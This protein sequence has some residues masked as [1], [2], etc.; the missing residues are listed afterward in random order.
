VLLLAVFILVVSASVTLAAQTTAENTKKLNESSITIG[1]GKPYRT[2]V[3][4]FTEGKLTDEDFHQASL[5]TSRVVAHLSEAEHILSAG[6]KDP[7]KAQ[8]DKALGLIK[9]IRHLL[10]VT[11]VTTTVKDSSGST[12]YQYEDKV[13]DDS[14]PIFRDMIAVQIIEPI[15]GLKRREAVLKGL[16]LADADLIRTS[17]LVN[18]G[19]IERRLNRAAGLLEKP[20]E[21]ARRSPHEGWDC[22]EN[23]H[24]LTSELRWWQ[25]YWH[26]SKMN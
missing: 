23:T 12:V 2:T 18:L 25:K 13:Q 10:P 3:E 4:R 17:V 7:A 22:R 8:I 21:A 16:R 20:E 5:L 15:A 6:K 19:F 14:I 9:I 24:W 26:S 1:S 11:T